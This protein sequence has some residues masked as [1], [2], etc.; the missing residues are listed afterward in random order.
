[1]VTV[2]ESF[3]EDV[4]EFVLSLLPRH[5]NELQS[6]SWKNILLVHDNWVTRLISTQ[7]RKVIYSKELLENPLLKNFQTE[8]FNLQKKIENGE[9]LKPYLSKSVDKYSTVSNPTSFTPD[10]DGLLNHWFIHHFHLGSK[11]E[12]DGFITRTK[13]LLYVKV[14]SDAICFIDILDHKSFSNTDLLR[15]V[16][17]NWPRTIEEFRMPLLE[18]QPQSHCSYN[19]SDEEIMVLR[20]RGGSSLVVIDGSVYAFVITTS[21]HSSDSMERVGYFHEVLLKIMSHLEDKKLDFRDA[22]FAQTG[23]KLDVLKMKLIFDNPPQIYPYRIIEKTS[24]IAF[25][26][27][28]TETKS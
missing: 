28:P 24:S 13:Q 3:Y 25:Y 15:I 4:K 7:P 9:N 21:G 27:S 12:N 5:R 6:E 19:W 10:K 18:G 22:I 2:K 23:V 1:M 14:F 8:I 17:R 16:K 11:L 20:K 26:H